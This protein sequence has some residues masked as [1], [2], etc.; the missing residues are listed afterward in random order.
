[1]T[2]FETE[3]V[4]VEELRAMKAPYNPRRISDFQMEALQRAMTRDGCIENLV[5]N[6]QT[7]CVVSGHQR[8]DAASAL[9]WATLPVLWID[10]SEEDEKRI[11]V[12]MNKI[13]GEFDPAE[14]AYI[15]RDISDDARELTGFTSAEIATLLDNV[16]GATFDLD[17]SDADGFAEG[18]Q[19]SDKDT[20]TLEVAVP[21]A[22]TNEESFKADVARWCD[23]HGLT[24]YRFRA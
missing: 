20:V 1:M 9:G 8:I 6:K 18:S 12:A 23:S 2:E 5:V 3:M 17:D 11:N 14:L 22:M 13:G 19:F 7:G 4:A 10:V 15:L 16:S 24:S 21:K